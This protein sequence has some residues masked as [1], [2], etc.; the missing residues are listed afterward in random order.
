MVLPQSSL[1]TRTFRVGLIFFITSTNSRL[2]YF[3]RQLCHYGPAIRL[4]AT[5]NRQTMC[6]VVGQLASAVSSCDTWK[7]QKTA[8]AHSASIAGVCIK[9]LS[10]TVVSKGVLGEHLLLT[11]WS[12]WPDSSS[13]RQ[14][15][16]ISSYAIAFT[17]LMLPLL[18]AP[19]GC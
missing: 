10:L 1:I 15:R 3:Q 14:L 17:Q 5:S 12:T 9:L 8:E 6:G 18:D 4:K 16:F 2:L 19:I 13:L 11:F 7:R